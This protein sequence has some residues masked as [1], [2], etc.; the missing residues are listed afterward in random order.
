MRLL[1]TAPRRCPCPRRCLARKEH[2][3]RYVMHVR[4]MQEDSFFQI[5]FH[6]TDPSE[7]EEYSRQLEAVLYQIRILKRRILDLEVRSERAKSS[8]QKTFARLYFFRLMILNHMCYLFKE[9]GRD[10]AESL[11]RY[12]TLGDMG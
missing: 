1:P 9:V 5:I 4:R 10:I 3:R 12:Y 7:A 6:R 8:G 11:E 2:E